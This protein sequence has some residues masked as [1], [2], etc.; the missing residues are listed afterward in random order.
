MN[1]T[2]KYVIECFCGLGSVLHVAST[3]ELQMLHRTVHI[4]KPRQATLEEYPGSGV[5]QKFEAESKPKIG[6]DLKEFFLK[7]MHEKTLKNV[8][9]FPKNDQETKYALTEIISPHPP[10]DQ[11]NRP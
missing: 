1:T 6:Q 8:C 9:F 3:K 11:I 5:L 4:Y 2:F 7:R 10:P